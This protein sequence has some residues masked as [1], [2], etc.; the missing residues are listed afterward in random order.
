M[1]FFPGFGIHPGRKAMWSKSVASFMD[2]REYV[3]EKDVYL[4]NK[5]LFYMAGT[6]VN[7]LEEMNKYLFH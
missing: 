1:W 3:L 4:P 5:D 7:P 6:T 2:Q